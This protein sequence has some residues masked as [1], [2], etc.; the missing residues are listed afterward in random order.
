MTSNP[1]PSADS[2][3]AADALRGPTGAEK[4][5]RAPV[6]RCERCEFRAADGECYCRLLL[7]DPCAEAHEC[8][9]DHRD[10]WPYDIADA[11]RG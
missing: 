2:T 11:G 6:I 10:E 7:C 8:A 1:R 5:P 4:S 3:G 9:W